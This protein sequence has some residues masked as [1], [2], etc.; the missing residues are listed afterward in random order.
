MKFDVNLSPRKINLEALVVF[1]CGFFSTMPIISIPIRGNYISL[2]TIVFLGELVL[3]LSNNTIGSLTLDIHIKQLVLWLF[4]SLFS[5]VFGTIFISLY[6]QLTVSGTY[7]IKIILYILFISYWGS[8][9]SREE[10][11][12]ALCRGLLYGSIVNIIWSIF[13]AACWYIAGIP[14]S[15]SVFRDYMHA[16]NL[17]YIGLAMPTGLYRSGGLNFDPAHLGFLCPFLVAY[18]LISEKYSL[19]V[20]AIGGLLASASTTGIV[21][22]CFI[23]VF[24]AW[25]K[26]AVKN[27][28]CTRIK[29]SKLYKALLVACVLFTF[30][31]IFHGPLFQIINKATSFL[32][33]RVE[34][35]Y[36]TKSADFARF[37]GPRLD[38]IRFFPTAIIKSGLLLLVGTG[39]GTSSYGYLD[40][41]SAMGIVQNSLYDIENTYLAYLFDTGIVGFIIFLGIM[42][43]ILR[44]YKNMYK[45]KELD[46]TGT[47]AFAGVLSMI[48]S[49]LFYHYILF[50]P[51]VLLTVVALIHMD[52][53]E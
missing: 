10:N 26:I 35:T 42:Y 29:L 36:L 2:F 9:R 5:S 50:A 11:N 32:F 21:C 51:Q 7:I 40:I 17:L 31:I 45:R 30:T 14:I 48:L 49:F 22:S 41:A 24:W 13:D 52:W 39:L 53:Y 15:N 8:N 19:L 16:N 44:Y 47:I 34:T 23:F 3:M 43:R 1:A 4:I 20:L 46:F 6:S 33:S 37:G 28:Y 12:N 18:S 27:V 38:F 25:N